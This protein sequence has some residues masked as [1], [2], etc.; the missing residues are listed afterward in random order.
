MF[1]RALLAFIL[2]SAVGVGST[3]TAWSDCQSNVVAYPYP[4]YAGYGGY[5]S[6]GPRVAYY[7]AVPIRTYPVVYGRDFVHH[8]HHDPHNNG[9]TISFGF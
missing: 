6:Y 8:H 4:T 2:V 9:L 5:N 1:K 3:A 7:P